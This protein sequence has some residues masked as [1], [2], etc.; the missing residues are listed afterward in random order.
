MVRDLSLNLATT[1]S[2]EAV[3]FRCVGS[4]LVGI[5]SVPERPCLR[6]VLVV[7]GGPQYRVGSHR[8]FTLLARRLA[9]N[10]IP[11]MRFDYR[12][13]GDSDGDPRSFEQIDDDIKAAVDYFCKRVSGMTEVVLWGLC[14]AASAL[15]F[16]AHRD[17][18]VTGLVL[19]NPF[20]YTVQGQARAYVKHYYWSRLKQREYWRMVI[21]GQ[22]DWR[23]SCRSF[24]QLLS[25]GFTSPNRQSTSNDR[26]SRPSLPDRMR[27]GL[28]RFKGR[29]LL[30]LSGEDLVAREFN[31]TVGRSKD[32]QQ[33]LA[34]DRISKHSMPNANHTFSRF[35]WR[36]EVA[37]VTGNWVKSF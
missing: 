29:V 14:D 3:T 18:R 20:V 28:G 4:S 2:D 11:V 19:L 9:E 23:E 24:L 33:L 1:V 35:E 21:S 17:R 32:W 12:G 16:Y 36:E 25:T 6:G 26:N 15:L 5:L 8:Q 10:G 34:E 22:F 30:I 31:D 37:D 27:E 7:V 13:I